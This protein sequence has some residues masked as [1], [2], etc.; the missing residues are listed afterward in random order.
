MFKFLRKTLLT[1]LFA[2]FASQA[3]AMWFQ[4]DWLDP[5]MQGVGTNRYAY[6]ANDPINKFDV[7]GNNWRYQNFDSQEEADDYFSKQAGDFY[8]RARKKEMAT[9]SMIWLETKSA[10][11]KR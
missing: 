2:T 6:S 11:T 8:S 5:T 1:A 4:P 9:A 10:S 3:S 7:T